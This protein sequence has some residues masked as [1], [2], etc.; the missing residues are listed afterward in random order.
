MYEK[1]GGEGEH[2]G[3]KMKRGKRGG[4]MSGAMLRWNLPAN[5]GKTERGG[6]FDE[7][8]RKIETLS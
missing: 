3:R 2:L 5:G 1:E 6:A 8:G 7:E 4:K